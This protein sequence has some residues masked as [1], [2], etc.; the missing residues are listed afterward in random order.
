MSRELI[1]FDGVFGKL[2]HVLISRCDLLV[3]FEAVQGAVVI[4]VYCT[5]DFWSA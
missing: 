1:C 2:I 4:V 3:V 5:V